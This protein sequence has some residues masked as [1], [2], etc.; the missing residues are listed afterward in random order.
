MNIAKLGK[1]L[2]AAAGA[3][4]VVFALCVV[5]M[6]SDAAIWRAFS[7]CMPITGICLFGGAVLS[8]VNFI[9]KK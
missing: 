4:V 5:F 2:F 6:K 9:G 8:I 7:V 1:L 3:A